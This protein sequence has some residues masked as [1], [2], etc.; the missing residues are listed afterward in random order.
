MT[1]YV[2]VFKV[3][4]CVYTVITCIDNGKSLLFNLMLLV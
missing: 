3:D 1:I 4:L 2:L